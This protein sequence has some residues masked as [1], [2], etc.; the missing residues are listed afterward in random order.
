MLVFC[1]PHQV[2]LLPQ[3][4]PCNCALLFAYRALSAH[5]PLHPCAQPHA[6]AVTGY[7]HCYS[8]LPHFYALSHLAL[9]SPSPQ[10]IHRMVKTLAGHIR[11]DAIAV[12][13]TKV[14]SWM[15]G[16]TESG[17]TWRSCMVMDQT[18]ADKAQHK[19]S[20]AAAGL[21]SMMLP[22]PAL[23]ARPCLSSS[24]LPCFRRAAALHP[25]ECR[26]CACGRM[27]PS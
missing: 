7:P 19:K 17:A 24:A 21:R 26:A 12:S 2:G 14:G 27:A 11:K 15:A 8:R 4:W 20:A 23:Q 1:S 13:L 9:P 16:G 3:L 10:F 5:G 25:L 18:A 22:C 6:A